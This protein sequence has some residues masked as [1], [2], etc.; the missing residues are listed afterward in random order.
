MKEKIAVIGAGAWGTTIANILSDNGYEVYLW[1]R[2]KWFAEVLNKSYE[3]THYLQGIR[4][5]R[6]LHFCTDY[7]K[8]VDKA[9]VVFFAVP[10]QHLRE[11]AKKFS[12]YIRHGTIIVNL[13]KG[14]ECTTYKRMSEI[15]MDELNGNIIA[16]LSGPNHSIEIAKKK[17]S[18]TVIASKHTGCLA[19]IKGILSTSYFKVYPHDDIVGVEICGA[20]KNIPAIASGIISELNYGDNALAGVITLG[21]SEMNTIGRHL[22]AKRSTV[23]GLAGVGDLVVTCTGKHSRNQFVGREL[24]QGKPLGEITELLHGMVAEGV[25][26]TKVVYDL[27]QVHNLKMPLTTEIYNVLYNKKDISTAIKDLF[28]R[29]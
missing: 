8:T 16:V 14:I 10:S 23:Y 2:T 24:A 15:L 13:A 7:A 17:P 22:G 27:S 28:E 21:L 5:N 11:T 4:L 20:V 6:N 26:T 25:E 9:M 1:V 19:Y 3:N 29:I 18:A 12:P